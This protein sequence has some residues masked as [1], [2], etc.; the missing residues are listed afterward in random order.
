ME[1]QRIS[2]FVEIDGRV[3]LVPIAPEKAEIFIGMLPAFQSGE[4]KEARLIVLSPKVVEHVTAAGYE[5][6][7]CVMEAQQKVFAK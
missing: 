7:K 2:V 6:G 5:F 1:I 4:Q 3:C